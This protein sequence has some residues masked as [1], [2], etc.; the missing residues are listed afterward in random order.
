MNSSELEKSSHLR[1]LCGLTS[2]HVLSRLGIATSVSSPQILQRQ[3]LKSP[4][5]SDTGH[6]LPP[7]EQYKA[8]I[9]SVDN[10]LNRLNQTLAS[11]RLLSEQNAKAKRE[12]AR[13]PPPPPEPTRQPVPGTAQPRDHAVP[14]IAPPSG[15]QDPKAAAAAARYFTT[16][17]K[18]ARD[19]RST[20]NSQLVC[21]DYSRLLCKPLYKCAR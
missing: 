2:P 9:E 8:S 20:Q 16:I 17:E 15:P 5:C 3:H 14:P 11:Y 21:T 12:E 13:R 19:L 18:I 6:P 7:M 1:H 4:P 10:A